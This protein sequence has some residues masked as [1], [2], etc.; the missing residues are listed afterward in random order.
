[1]SDGLPKWVE[2]L[3]A[4]LQDSDHG[5]RRNAATRLGMW[6]KKHDRIV[7]AL[8]ASHQNDP[9]QKVRIAAATALQ[10]LGIP[11]AQDSVPSRASAAPASLPPAPLPSP[12]EVPPSVPSDVAPGSP[13]HVM[14]LERRLMYLEM[15]TQRLRA[16]ISAAPSATPGP[17]R[18]LPHTALLNDSFLSRAFAVWG[19]A[20][21]AQLLLSIPIYV[22]FLLFLT[23]G[24]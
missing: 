21:V 22:L 3:I 14:L 4:D 6:G 9:D 2:N 12:P 13:Q 16:T 7:S 17:V 5:V 15:E 19:H 23:A 20:F 24:G 18:S 10:G 8:Q 1:M 11:V